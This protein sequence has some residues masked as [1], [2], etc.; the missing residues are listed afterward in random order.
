MKETVKFSFKQSVP[1]A[2]GYIFLGIAF[3]IL[4]YEADYN[5]LWSLAAAV[6]IY[7]GS[8]QF[9]LVSL[10]AAGAPV[11][12]V[13]AVTLLVNARHIFYGLGFIE[14]FRGSGKKYPYLVFALTDETYSVLCSCKYP[15][16]VDEKNA[17]F[18]ISLFNHCY[19]I[20]GCTLGGI[21]GNIIP[22]DCTGID[23]SMTALFTVIFVNQ[24]KEYKTHVPAVVGICVSAVFLAVFG[25]DNFLL[26]SLAVTSAVLI[27]LKPRLEKYLCAEA[28]K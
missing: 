26:P 3:G 2:F 10:L 14:K 21:A 11:L 8:M 5:A 1:V 15:E 22:F 4:M 7:A 19:W 13:A 6:F 24:W 28:E 18:F 16:N 20:L 23:F 27:M 17:M 12:S 9:V 25:A